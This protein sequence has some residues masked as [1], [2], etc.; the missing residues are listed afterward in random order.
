MP[1]KISDSELEI[2]RVLWDAGKPLSY[3]EIR[4][5]LE[6]KTDWKKSTIQTLLGRL[7]KKEAVITHQHYVQLY[8]SNVNEEEYIRAE[9]LNFIDKLFGGN[10][11]KLV[12]ALCKDGKLNESDV[13]EL[14]SFFKVGGDST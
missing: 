10:A 14:K 7:C 13:D 11:M 1:T 5:I 3:A 2:M 12:T 8:S 6:S 4:T 9:G